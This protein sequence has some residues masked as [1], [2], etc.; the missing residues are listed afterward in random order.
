MHIKWAGVHGAWF[1]ID[2]MICGYHKCT[3]IWNNSIVADLLVNAS[4]GIAIV[5]CCRL[6]D[7]LAIIWRLQQVPPNNCRRVYNRVKLNPYTVAIKKIIDGEMKKTVK[8]QVCMQYFR[9]LTIFNT[10][11]LKITCILIDCV[12][13][14]LWFLA[15]IIFWRVKLG[16]TKTDL[17]NS[18]KFYTINVSHYMVPCDEE[19]EWYSPMK[20]KKL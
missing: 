2:P 11:K 7:T 10:H 13:S 14:F 4:Q 3:L 6:F 17:P 19:L 8:I 9:M 18:S 20:V 1:L 5:W 16:K 12:Q 15:S